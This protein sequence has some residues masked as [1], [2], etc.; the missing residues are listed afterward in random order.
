LVKKTVTREVSAAEA[1]VFLEKALDCVDSAQEAL[2]KG[3]W[4]RASREAVQGAIFSVDALLGT[5][6]RLRSGA[7]DHT[8]AATLLSQKVGTEDARKNAARFIKII[9]KKNV[10]QYEG[11]HAS[12]AESRSLT[13]DAERLLDWVNAEIASM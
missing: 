8:Q 11:R 3:K 9:T 12:Q 10:V 2:E 4:D 13:R 1:R 7:Q 6:Y 5:R